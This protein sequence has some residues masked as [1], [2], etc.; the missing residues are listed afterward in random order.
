[1]L[2]QKPEI[3]LDRDSP[4]CDFSVV[5]RREGC[6]KWLGDTVIDQ[7]RQLAQ[8]RGDAR[9]TAER[10][11]IPQRKLSFSQNMPPL[12]QCAVSLRRLS[13]FRLEL[14][15]ETLPRAEK[16]PN[17]SMAEAL[18]TVPDASRRGRVPPRQRLTSRCTLRRFVRIPSSG[19]KNAIYPRCIR[20]SSGSASQY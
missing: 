14:T 9:F 18:E 1:L 7:G 20:G 11:A 4:G 5:E 8:M 16:P 2:T 13:R 10:P 6:G 12:F 3:S 17:P 15:L 19:Q